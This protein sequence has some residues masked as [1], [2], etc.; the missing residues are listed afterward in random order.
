MTAGARGEAARADAGGLLGETLPAVRQLARPAEGPAGADEAVWRRGFGG[1]PDRRGFAPVPARCDFGGRVDSFGLAARADAGC[2]ARGFWVPRGG[3][4]CSSSSEGGS[5]L[6]PECST[7][8]AS[9]TSR[10]AAASAPPAVDTAA[11]AP[12][13]KARR[14]SSSEGSLIRITTGVLGAAWVRLRTS[15]GCASSAY[16]TIKSGAATTTALRTASAG[17]T[18]TNT[19]RRSKASAR[20]SARSASA[21]MM[22]IAAFTGPS[23]AQQQNDSCPVCPVPSR[24]HLITLGRRPDQPISRVL[25]GK[26]LRSGR[27]FAA[28]NGRRP[29]W[30]KVC[31]VRRRVALRGSS[32]PRR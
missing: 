11:A 30:L 9:G 18:S 27:P 32:R 25:P 15:A 22:R 28:R 2:R 16:T 7:R 29:L 10:A 5:R 19:P 3:V 23:P 20:E 17:A 6:P 4:G 31:S 24:V 8:T 26:I 12:G 14:L 21:L 13:G 1:G